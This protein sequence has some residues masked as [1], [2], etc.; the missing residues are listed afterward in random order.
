MQARLAVYA[1]LRWLRRPSNAFIGHQITPNSATSAL[2]SQHAR[3]NAQ[4]PTHL[5][6]LASTAADQRLCPG[7]TGRNTF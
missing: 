2:E 1:H 5:V 7:D 6:T 4:Q 3:Q